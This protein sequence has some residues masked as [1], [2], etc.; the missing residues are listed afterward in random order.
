MVAAVQCTHAVLDTGLDTGD[1][2][3]STETVSS[4]VRVEVCLI[5]LGRRGCESVV[6]VGHGGRG[7]GTLVVT[8]TM[9][10]SDIL[11]WR[12]MS[13]QYTRTRSCLRERG[14]LTPVVTPF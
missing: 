9:P 11:R 14:G 2:I 8:V 1:S 5:D 6:D 7:Q 13:S 4:E 10:R 3:S 12:V